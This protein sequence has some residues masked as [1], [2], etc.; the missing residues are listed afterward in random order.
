MISYKEK[1]KRKYQTDNIDV[2]TI[3]GYKRG[4]NKIQNID[5]MGILPIPRKN[6]IIQ[7][8]DRLD[9]PRD[10]DK[11]QYI[12][13]SSYEEKKDVQASVRPIHVIDK[14]TGL[15]RQDI[16][17]FEIAGSP[18]A[19]NLELEYINSIEIIERNNNNNVNMIM[20]NWDDLNIEYIEDLQISPDN[21]EV[22]GF[23]NEINRNDFG[24]NNNHGNQ[25]GSSGYGGYGNQGGN[26]GYGN[27][28]GRSG[29]G[30]QGGRSGQSGQGNQGRSGQG[31]GYYEEENNNIISNYRY[32]NNYN[33][34]DYY[35]N[36]DLERIINAIKEVK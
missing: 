4:P 20:N 13:Q 5:Q 28:G 12:I 26:S 2:L 10:Y 23:G 21:N 9:I 32:Q 3:E 34:R 6:L 24:G 35:S 19:H 36:E 31:S 30:N 27:Q 8:I 16:D 25:G 15:E 1:P 17:N 18:L 33:R 22:L 29:P 11:Y 14:E 7:N